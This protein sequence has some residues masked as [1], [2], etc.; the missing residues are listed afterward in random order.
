MING[1]TVCH[2][3]AVDGVVCFGEFPYEPGVL[4]V[5]GS[6]P[7]S[8][9]VEFVSHTAGEPAALRLES[10]FRGAN[11]ELVNVFIVDN[12]GVVIPDAE[13]PVIFELTEGV[14]LGTGN[15]RPDDTV[16]DDS[17]CSTTIAGCAQAII[18]RPP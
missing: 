11:V 12:L 15:G 18:R 10:A 3:K 2:R 5:K 13:L 17:P 9:T 16:R 4:C 1:R 8:Q 6:G 7:G 14:L